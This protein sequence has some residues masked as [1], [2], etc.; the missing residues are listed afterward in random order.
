MATVLSLP[1]HAHERWPGIPE[2]I[3][4]RPPPGR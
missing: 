2:E 3:G 4:I 1:S